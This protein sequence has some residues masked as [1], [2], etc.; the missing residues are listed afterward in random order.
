MSPL[1]WDCESDSES[2]PELVLGTGQTALPF[3]GMVVLVVNLPAPVEVMD[4]IVDVPYSETRRW[5]VRCTY[6]E[7]S[8]VREARMVLDDWRC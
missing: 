5:F 4:M 8:I 7:P 3:A 1:L 2:I 6:N